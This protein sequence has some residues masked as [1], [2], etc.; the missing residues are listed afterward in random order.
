MEQPPPDT[1]SPFETDPVA[2][3]MSVNSEQYNE[4]ARKKAAQKDVSPVEDVKSEH[5]PNDPG[6][7]WNGFSKGVRQQLSLN[8]ICEAKVKQETENIH[9]IEDSSGG[10][11]N[12]QIVPDSSQ[13]LS[14]CSGGEEVQ[15]INDQ[16]VPD[17]SQPLSVCSGGEAVQTIN[18][19]IVPDSS[20]LLS[21]CSGGEEV[22]IMETSQLQSGIDT[23]GS[24]G[25]SGRLSP[26]LVAAAAAEWP[27]CECRSPPIRRWGKPLN[28]TGNGLTCYCSRGTST[29]P[30]PR[31]TS[32][33]F[34]TRRSARIKS[35]A[36]SSSSD[37]DGSRKSTNTR[38]TDVS[39]KT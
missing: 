15:I 31:S 26:L 16:I 21:D 5:D 22:E 25:Y 17:S 29:S 12:D 38:T 19:Q 9:Q 36:R 24:A 8:L 30:P 39:G 28:I 35:R 37:S 3:D 18:D 13:R 4:V 2:I 14:V 23:T 33:R 27:N 1:V 32:T 10:D 7:A 20:Q 6:L 34:P 11:L